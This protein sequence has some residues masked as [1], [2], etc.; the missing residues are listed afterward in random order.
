MDLALAIIFLLL[1]IGGVVVR[2]TYFYIPLRELKRRAEKHKPFENGSLSE[3][4]SI[5][6]KIKNPW[7]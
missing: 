6:L 3:P 4:I 2:K 7:I 1:A 5:G